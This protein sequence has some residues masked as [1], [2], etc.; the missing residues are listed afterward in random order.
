MRIAILHHQF[1]RKGGLERY[2]F[3]LLQ[4]F[5]LAEDQTTLTVYAQDGNQQLVKN[6][7]IIKYQLNWLPKALRNFYFAKRLA[8]HHRF[9]EY[10]CTIS[11]MRSI[12]QE[13]V[14]SGGTHCGLLVHT[15]KKISL[16]D[17]WEIRAEQKSFDASKLIVAQSKMIADEIANFYGVDSRKIRCLLPPINVERFNANLRH[18]RTELQQKWQ[19]N[20]AKKTLL[21]PSTAQKREGLEPLLKAFIQLPSDQYELLIVGQKPTKAKL[22]ENARFLGFVEEMA[23]LYT[24]VDFTILPSYYEPFGLAV[25]ESL[26]C[27]TPVIISDYVGAKELLQEEYGMII[28]S[29]TVNAI[30]STIEQACQKIFHI[31][32]DFAERY[33]LTLSTHIDQLKAL[34]RRVSMA[35]KEI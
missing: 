3:D 34:M 14:I 35:T 27:A 9:S 16:L 30:R 1:K 8:Y 18:Q 10:D 25:A 33:K 20:P 2:L 11:L 6:C 32:E 5:A 22:P 23:E 12:S 15:D 24:A 21:F 4:G 29:V 26:A 19:I 13:I 7:R 31:P 17:R 28:R